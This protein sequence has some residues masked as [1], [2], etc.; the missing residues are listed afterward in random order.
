MAVLCIANVGRSFTDADG[1]AYVAV[2]V[3]L[4]AA[5]ER[6]AGVVRS[7]IREHCPLALVAAATAALEPHLADD[8]AGRSLLTPMPPVDLGIIDRLAEQAV[9]AATCTH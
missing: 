6:Q 8:A 2:S 1:R 3:P 9:Q 4:D 5:G 7:H